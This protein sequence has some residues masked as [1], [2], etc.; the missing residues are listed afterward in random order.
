MDLTKAV[1]LFKELEAKISNNRDYLRSHESVTRVLL[2]DPVLEILGWNVR[3]PNLVQLEFKTAT[4]K[5]KRADYLLKHDG[6]DLAIVE[7]KRYDPSFNPNDYRDQ[8]N[9]Y[10]TDS[11]VAFFILTN[12][13][14]WALYKRE[15]LTPLENLEP[16][17]DF[18][19]M[20]DNPTRCA[21][22]ALSIWMPNLASG[23]PDPVSTS[24]FGTGNEQPDTPV[25][26]NPPT[27]E[28]DTESGW[29]LLKNLS[30]LDKYS[31]KPRHIKFP[32]GCTEQFRSSSVGVLKETAKWLI[33]NGKLKSE[34]AQIPHPKI[35]DR[36][37]ASSTEQLHP[38]GQRFTT[39]ELVGA[40]VYIE[41][42]WEAQDSIDG[43]IA[44]LE[45]FGVDPSNVQVR[46]NR[47]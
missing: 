22:N 30:G 28:P 8:G 26:S 7:T 16:I 17:V 44:L 37:I 40:D 21:L 10:A 46:L 18:N 3:D 13:A 47:V 23:D 45:H 36:Y 32:D 41:K 25:T 11:G 5:R 6:Q 29:I 2:V 12:G 35:Q 43:A 9:G 34:N 24:L 20:D 27:I 31:P 4:Q 14:R 33:E 19:I 42:N 38:S 15:V 1:A 39:S